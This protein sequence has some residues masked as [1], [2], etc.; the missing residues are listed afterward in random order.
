MLNLSC[1]CY[2]HSEVTNFSRKEL[3]N[4]L[5]NSLSLTLLCFQF[6]NALNMVLYLSYYVFYL[7][8]KDFKRI[9]LER[10]RPD[11]VCQ[12]CHRRHYDRSPFFP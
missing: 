4:T 10:Y 5:D 12:C 8:M 1:I 11:V 6:C 9:T 3:I 2:S 7:G